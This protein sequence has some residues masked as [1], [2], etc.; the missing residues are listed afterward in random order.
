MTS[1]AC[2]TAKLHS[3]RR[4][5]TIARTGSDDL[6]GGRWSYIDEGGWKNGSFTSSVPGHGGRGGDGVGGLRRVDRHNDH[7]HKAE[8]RPGDRH[9]WTQRQEL[10]PP[11]LPWAAKGKG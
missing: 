9:R 7:H 11:C 2:I 10:Q 1:S 4:R 6:F 5:T 8:D 3:N